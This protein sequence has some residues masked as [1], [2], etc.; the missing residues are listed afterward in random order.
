[1]LRDQL[2]NATM[3]DRVLRRGLYRV[4]EQANRQARKAASRGHDGVRNNINGI[5]SAIGFG[6][7]N[8]GKL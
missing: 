6:E 1:M 3:A 7:G 5:E 8:T 2:V 4:P